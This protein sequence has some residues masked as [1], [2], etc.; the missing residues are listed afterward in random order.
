MK[1]LEVGEAND[2]VGD[3]VGLPE[4]GGVGCPPAGDEV[5]LPED[6]VEDWLPINGSSLEIL[7]YSGAI[8]GC[9]EV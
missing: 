6:G 4:P 2:E 3:E 1:P 8:G 5:G 9:L 7:A